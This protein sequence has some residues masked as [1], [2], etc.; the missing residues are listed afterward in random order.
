MNDEGRTA[1][2]QK[3]TPTKGRTLGDPRQQFP[4]TSS[5]ALKRKS[6]AGKVELTDGTKKIIQP[7]S[8]NM[9]VLNESVHYALGH[10][11]KWRINQGG[12]GNF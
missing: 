3:Y 4:V 7:H 12:D 5:S 6:P 11:G 2:V 9:A 1:G 10:A 8:E